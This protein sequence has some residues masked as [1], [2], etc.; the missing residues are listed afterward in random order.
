VSGGSDTDAH[1]ADGNANDVGSSGGDDKNANVDDS[2]DIVAL[3][4]LRSSSSPSPSL[5]PSPPPPVVTRVRV[6]TNTDPLN[7]MRT[8]S[9]VTWESLASDAAAVGQFVQW[10]AGCGGVGD[11]S[12]ALCALEIRQLRAAASSASAAS[13]AAGRGRSLA[14]TTMAARYLLDTYLTAGGDAALTVPPVPFAVRDALAAEITRA[15]A[16]LDADDADAGHDDGGSDGGSDG[17]EHISDDCLK[18]SSFDAVSTLI[19][20]HLKA[21][22]IPAYN[23]FL[24]AEN[25]SC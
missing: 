5:S 14:K 18:A 6:D 23:L 1:D 2:G 3:L 21:E 22:V 20:A 13:V 7:Q 10:C 9:A 24:A 4:P 11:E 16:L 15:E 19:V 25:A 17:G 8:T 12:A